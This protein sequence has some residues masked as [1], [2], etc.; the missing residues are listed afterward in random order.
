MPVATAGKTVTFTSLGKQAGERFEASVDRLEF[1]EVTIDATNF[2]T[3]EVPNGRRLL[4]EGFSFS[5]VLAPP[6]CG[7]HGHLHGAT[8][9]C[10][11]GYR[12]DP[13]NPRNCIR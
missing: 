10:D 5:V 11:P 13:M 2:M 3:T 6:E 7:G 4:V 1:R 9:H 8:C 12:L